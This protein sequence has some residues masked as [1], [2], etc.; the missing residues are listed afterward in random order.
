[1]ISDEIHAPITLPGAR[2]VPFL[3]LG[4]EASLCGIAI[5]GASKGWNIA[6]LKCALIVTD[7][8]EMEARLDAALPEHLRYH[9]GHLGV[10]ASLAAFEHGVPW[11]DAMIAHLDQNRARLAEL[12][13]EHLPEV[14]Y[15]PPE[16]GYLAW[17]D[18]RALELGADPAAL[19][20]ERGRVALSPG[21]G[22]GTGGE[23]FARLNFATS[24][25][26]LAEAVVRMAAAVRGPAGAQT[27]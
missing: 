12:L 10:I 24:S 11:L 22:F 15:L 8:A 21:P 27:G 23:G 4:G 17:L 1:V 14:G 5:V 19:F 3:S 13:A 20:L 25:A 16:A 18:C 9:V 2:H 26:L 6:G 7:S